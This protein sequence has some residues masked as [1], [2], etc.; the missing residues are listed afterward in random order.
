M[1]DIDPAAV[2]AK[3]A[4]MHTAFGQPMRW[5][6][7]CDALW[8]CEPYRLADAL[9]TA[10]DELDRIATHTAE[11]FAQRDAAQAALTAEQGKTARV[12]AF[13]AGGP[14]T[15]CRT[16]WHEEAPLLGMRRPRIECVEVPMD[17]LRAALADG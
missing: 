9:A 17:D 15:A 4:N 10:L 2:K 16:V 8:P 11:A 6:A 7:P 14:D 13:F 12:Q 5:C 1:S 3:H